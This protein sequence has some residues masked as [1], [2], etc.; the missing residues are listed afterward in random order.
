MPNN[1][2]E[3]LGASM[4]VD[5]RGRLFNFI[6]KQSLPL[7]LVFS[8]LLGM[9]LN[10]VRPLLQYD[11]AKIINGE[12]WRLI[13]GNFMHLSWGH[14]FLNL[15]GLLFV[16]PL[17]RYFYSVPKCWTIT[18]FSSIGI[19]AGL[20]LFSPEVEWYVGLSG[21]LHAMFAVAVISA[22]EQKLQGASI[23]FFFLLSKL[24]IQSY[25]GSSTLF[26]FVSEGRVIWQSHI[27]GVASGIL[28]S[29]VLLKRKR[30][31][32]R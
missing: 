3:V 8:T 18:I 21:L 13:T 27:Y 26:S 14:L 4:R 15:V 11:R 31:E 25:T 6:L 30:E 17:L 7:F 9:L 23:L 16:Y 10:N 1:S 28:I 24:A 2:V 5:E 20:F 19:G 12:I 32:S 29:I 22:I